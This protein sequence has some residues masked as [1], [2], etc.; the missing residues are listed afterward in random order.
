LLPEGTEPEPR[1][2]L[3]LLFDQNEL[4]ALRAKAATPIYQPWMGRLRQQARNMLEIQPESLIGRF[5]FE[6]LLYTRPKE[7]KA[8]YSWGGSRPTIHG[9]AFAGMLDEDRNMLRH[10]ARWM[11]SVAHCEYWYNDVAGELPGTLWHHRSFTEFQVT[12]QVALCLDWAG[13]MLT[14]EGRD[15]IRDA[16]ARR[17]LPRMQQDFIDANTQ[18]IRAMNQGIAFNTGR[19]MGLLALCKAWPRTEIRLNE[20]QDDTMEMFSRT[21]TEDGGTVEGPG[22]WQYTLDSGLPGVIALAKYRNCP[23]AELLPERMRRASGYP[24]VLASTAQTGHALSIGDSHSCT[25][26]RTTVAA[27]IAHIF[28]GSESERLAAYVLR[29]GYVDG[30]EDIPLLILFGPRTLPKVQEIVPEFAVLE[31]TGQAVVCRPMDGVGLV[32]LQMIGAAPGVSGSHSHDDRGNILLEAGGEEI[33]IDRGI[34]SYSGA[35]GE[36]DKR[37]GAHNLLVPDT[38]DGTAPKQD[39]EHPND[40]CP[41]AR[42]QNGRFRA[43]IEPTE[44]WPDHVVRCTRTI[45]SETPDV[46]EITDELELTQSLGATLHLH[47]P[48]DARQEAA[49]WVL[50][51]K[52]V[53]VLIEPQWPV[54]EATFA[55]DDLGSGGT[56]YGH[57]QLRSAPARSHRLVTRIT[58]Q[59]R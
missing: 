57:L 24:P 10:A 30:G 3:G 6:P 38:P 47:T 53:Q 39:R 21:F 58:V 7:R 43:T 28:P 13:S 33:L 14:P 32:R 23:A 2:E 12:Y 11:L 54:A 36:L 26:C 37:P 17:G 5:A 34:G 19:L 46:F 27:M 45:D 44:A 55:A 15:L 1:V 40:I 22:Y 48:C 35:L 18:Y 31:K 20:A 49:A 41:E 8:L 42:Y 16:I 29:N 9:L 59:K 51:G 50:I 4:E 52:G 25:V 56:A